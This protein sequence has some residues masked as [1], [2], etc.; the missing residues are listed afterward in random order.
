MSF[1]RQ[2]PRRLLWSAI[3]VL[4]LGAIAYAHWGLSGNFTFVDWYFRFPVT[5]FLMA[6]ALAEWKFAWSA[7][8]AFEENE[9]L[10]LAWF[11][12]VLAA[13]FRVTGLTISH[14]IVPMM[15]VSGIIDPAVFRDAGQVISGPF[16]VLSL[17]AGLLL[18]LRTHRRLGFIANPAPLDYVWI[19]GSCAFAL[20]E[21]Y[22]IVTYYPVLAHTKS[23][24]GK[25]LWLMDPLLSVLLIVAILVWRHAQQMG[26]GYVAQCWSTYAIA[27]MLTTVGDIGIWADTYGLIAWPYTS[28]TWLIWI[29][30]AAAFAIAP[31]YQVC[32]AAHVFEIRDAETAD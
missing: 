29:P 8:S 2:T 19:A 5:M 26:G 14:V 31:C 18:V 15:P 21:I 1:S 16:M 13:G 6:A 30:A 7:W 11:L 23:L 28:L 17:G 25:V 20:R 24:P 27:A 4:F 9:T 12:M 3:A 10:E 32:A 22:E